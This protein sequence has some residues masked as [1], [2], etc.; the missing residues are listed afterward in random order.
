MLPFLAVLGSEALE[1]GVVLNILRWG[2]T[3]LIGYGIAESFK[4][5]T[6]GKKKKVDAFLSKPKT[7]IF[8]GETDDSE[9]A[10]NGSSNSASSSVDK[11]PDGVSSGSGVSSTSEAS[12]SAVSGDTLIDVLKSSGQNTADGLKA[13]AEAIR[14]LNL[15]SG[16]SGAGAD[17][18]G[19]ED[20]LEAIANASQRGVN[21]LQGLGAILGAVVLSLEGIRSQLSNSLRVD[22]PQEVKDSALATKQV[23]DI[24]KTPINVDAERPVLEG[25][26]IEVM[27]HSLGIQS[28]TFADI[29]TFEVSEEDIPDL[30]GSGIDLSKIFEFLRVS[31]QLQSGGQIGG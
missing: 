15:A 24:L 26:P 2:L 14:G 5:E 6:E 8:S 17:F 27:A 29:N 16:S 30:P 31:N 21:A 9:T 22:L 18:T 25:S 23:M 12:L 7:D 10:V 28:R 1:S 3:T 13:I 4:R 19:I 11:A 20:K